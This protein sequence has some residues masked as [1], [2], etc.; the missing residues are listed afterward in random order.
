MLVMIKL[1]CV[2]TGDTV[3]LGQWDSSR[4]E[5]DNFQRKL[6]RW[7]KDKGGVGVVYIMFVH[8]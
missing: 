6:T 4:D 2:L 5:N 1:H 7:T 8:S 3:G